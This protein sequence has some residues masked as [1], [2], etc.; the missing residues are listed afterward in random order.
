MLTRAL[1]PSPFPPVAPARTTG[2][3]LGAQ[4]MY[5][6]VWDA[7]T[8]RLLV[9]YLA[10]NVP[11]AISSQAQIAAQTSTGAI[12]IYNVGS[13]GIVGEAVATN[14]TRRRRRATRPTPST[15][16]PTSSSSATAVRTRAGSRS[17]TSRPA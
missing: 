8:S 11:T 6:V 7:A 4:G 17:G 12:G 2:R 16:T 13:T 15:R 5:N 1:M 3:Y 10:G 14:P 9:Y